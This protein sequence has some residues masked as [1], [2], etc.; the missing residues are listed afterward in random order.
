MLFPVLV[1][2]FLNGLSPTILVTFVLLYLISAFLV[3]D[4]L[5]TTLTVQVAF[6]PLLVWAVI[7]TVPV[8]LPVTFPADTVAIL[9]SLEDQVIVLLVALLGLIVADKVNESPTFISFLVASRLI[10]LIAI[11]RH[12]LLLINAYRANS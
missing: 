8:F 7:V 9:L 12:R 4:W 11:T 3:F 10:L 2:G 6:L 1:N 5:L